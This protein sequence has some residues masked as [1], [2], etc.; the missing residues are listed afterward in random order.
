MIYV[1]CPFSLVVADRTYTELSANFKQTVGVAC[2]PESLEVSRPQSFDG[3]LNYQA[4][5]EAVIGGQRSRGGKNV[6][7]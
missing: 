3:P 2:T 1:A 6:T 4:Y 5:R 7:K